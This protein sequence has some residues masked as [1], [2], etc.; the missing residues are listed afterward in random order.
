MPSGRGEWT[1]YIEG[2]VSPRFNGVSTQ[3]GEVNADADSAANKPDKGITVY[4][5][6]AG[7]HF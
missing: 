2:N 5:L 4:S 7:F 1:A 6:R 3:L